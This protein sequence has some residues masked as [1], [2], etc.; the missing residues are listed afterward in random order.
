[1]IEYSSQVK[2]KDVEILETNS[3]IIL[4]LIDLQCLILQE[5]ASLPSNNNDNNN[6]ILPSV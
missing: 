1:M 3:P 2:T 5:I 4:I 6:N